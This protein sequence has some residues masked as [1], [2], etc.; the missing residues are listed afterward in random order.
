MSVSNFSKSFKRRRKFSF[1]EVIS[2]KQDVSAHH[3]VKII[4]VSEIK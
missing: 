4:K 3:S 2:K 1:N